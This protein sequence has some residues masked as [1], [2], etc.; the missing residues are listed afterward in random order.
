MILLAPPAPRLP[1]A[2][3]LTYHDVIE[4]RGPGSV[5]FDCTSAELRAQLDFMAR[6]GAT[7]VSIPQIEAALDGTRA[8][9][10]RAVALTFADNY[11]GFL[12]RAWPLLKAR[13]IPVA[14]FVH[15]DYV[16][17]PVGRP[18]MTWAELTALQ[19]SGLVTVASQTR[20]HPAD[21]RALP[22]ARLDAEFVGAKA[23][24]ERRLGACHYLAYP[25][26]KYDARVAR[27]ARRAGYSLAFTEV[28]AP[29]DRAPDRWR[30]PRYVHTKYRLALANLSSSRAVADN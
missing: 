28:L 1:R 2:V 19:R 5:W 14:L 30:L 10:K 24:I 23:A 25:N 20:S 3:V 11:R 26:G 15:T 17:S 8:L 6:K 18:K 12:L 21:L 4:R 16:G 22:E 29:L 13:R 9:P 7:F 27:A